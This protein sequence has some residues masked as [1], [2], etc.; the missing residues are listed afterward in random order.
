MPLAQT[1]SPS[2]V[3]TA[4]SPAS[5]SETD[6]ISTFVTALPRMKFTL[7]ETPEGLSENGL[8]NATQGIE[9]FIGSILHKI[10][11]ADGRSLSDYFD[12]IKLVAVD[13]RYVFQ[14]PSNNELVRRLRQNRRQAEE[15][16]G[17]EIIYDATVSFFDEPP[18]P[19]SLVRTVIGTCALFNTYLVD[20][21]T[22]TGHPELTSVYIV[23]AE[24]YE[25]NGAEVQNYLPTFDSP[26]EINQMANVAEG[27]DTAMIVLTAV[28]VATITMLL[29]V[30]STRRQRERSDRDQTRF[31]VAT[32]FPSTGL[33]RVT[34]PVESDLS[35][36]SSLTEV[37]TGRDDNIL[38]MQRKVGKS[39]DQDENT[40]GDRKGADRMLS[41]AEI[42]CMGTI[43]LERDCDSVLP[44][45]WLRALHADETS[46][47]S[48]VS[49]KSAY[50]PQTKQDFE[51]ICESPTS[52]KFYS[53]V[54]YKSNNIDTV[55]S[56]TSVVEA[57]TSKTGGFPTFGVAHTSKLPV[58]DM[59]S[60]SS[61]TDNDAV[62]SVTTSASQFIRDLVWLENKIAM[63]NANSTNSNLD[64]L[65]RR[66]AG[67]NVN[68]KATVSA[69]ESEALS[70]A[71][72]D[73]YIPSGD[74]VDGLDIET[75]ADGPTVT[76][77]AEGSLLQG[78]L[79]PGSR[80]VAVDD[81]DTS[82]ASA[83]LILSLITSTATPTHKV[84]VL[85]FEGND[86]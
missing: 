12:D 77:I 85:Q 75:T 58:D 54:D 9:K 5:F 22:D 6:D 73:C 82:T 72:K 65:E 71:C 38:S 43:S 66:V 67:V 33:R 63:G 20:N 36:V 64:E 52:S 1:F 70:V 55:A 41:V 46:N 74:I 23:H 76:S 83:D 18:S 40:P 31:E 53:A 25:E 37:C 24:K 17:T 84:T 49:T 39:R 80:I 86:V 15:S 27:K 19:S 56:S 69:K 62:R 21:V 50:Y 32:S 79:S 78:H 4:I 44:K 48:L 35:I 26:N 8:S 60:S 29:L 2:S 45:S 51:S 47:R 7:L 10:Y 14:E 28:G 30:I 13:E 59:S 34:R 16:K 81:V 57:V 42:N 11:N 68:E 61:D 3:P